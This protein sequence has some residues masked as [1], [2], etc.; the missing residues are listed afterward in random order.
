MLF[1]ANCHLRII[2]SVQNVLNS[3]NAPET[4]R[5]SRKMKISRVYRK[6]IKITGFHQERKRQQRYWKTYSD[7]LSEPDPEWQQYLDHLNEHKR[8]NKAA[9]ARKEAECRKLEE[10]KRKHKECLKEWNRKQK[11]QKMEVRLQNSQEDQKV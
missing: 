2:F 7:A 6:V 9:K 1:S 5:V 11:K 8:E 4:R 10:E 3:A